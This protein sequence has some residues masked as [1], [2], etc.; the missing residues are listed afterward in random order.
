MTT[1]TV[2]EARTVHVPIWLSPEEESRLVALLAANEVTGQREVSEWMGT[3]MCTSVDI[4]GEAEAARALLSDLRE[5]GIEVK[6]AEARRVIGDGLLLEGYGEKT[7]S[8][9]RP[10]SGARRI[11]QHHV[12][13][14]VPVFTR[15]QRDALVLGV[16][17][18]TLARDRLLGDRLVRVRQDWSVGRHIRVYSALIDLADAVGE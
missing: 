17:V 14:S 3:R 13:V 10:G 8:G 6:R 7:G 5:H 18:S 12:F 2:R 16:P 1:D 9:R 11:H 4:A 15:L